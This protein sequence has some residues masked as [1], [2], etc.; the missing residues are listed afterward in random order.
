L[1][2]VVTQQRS[3]VGVAPACTAL[4]IPRATFYRWE[5]P[6][7]IV[8]ARPRQIA[9]ALPPEER[10]LVLSVLNEERFADLPPAEVYATLL[11]E[12]RYLCSIRT[13]YRVLAENEQVRERRA[14]L[15]HPV[16]QAPELLA[17]RPTKCGRG[18]SPS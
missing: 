10:R 5:K 1:M 15:R 7:G 12:G 3:S 13:M 17:T 11:D 14:Q 2:A 8:P 9:R 18:T 6:K 16:Y 4:S